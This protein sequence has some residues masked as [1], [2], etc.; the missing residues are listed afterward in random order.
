M[1]MSVFVAICQS[2]LEFRATGH[3]PVRRGT[4]IGVR[5]WF[6]SRRKLVVFAAPCIYNIYI[7]PEWCIPPESRFILGWQSVARICSR[8][9]CPNPDLTYFSELKRI[10][11]TR[12]IFRVMCPSLGMS[13]V[14]SLLSESRLSLSLPLNAAKPSV[15]RSYQLVKI[16][17]R[18]TS[19]AINF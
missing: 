18:S 2:M 11:D 1:S 8:V 9:F 3:Q 7:T 19:M 16:R 12:V 15:A 14:W 6:I 13:H 10:T 5:G 17:R 4:G